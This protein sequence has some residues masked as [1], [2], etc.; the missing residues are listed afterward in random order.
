MPR[1]LKVH[2]HTKQKSLGTILGVRARTT[3]TLSTET[4]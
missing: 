2:V 1:D 3:R 4:V